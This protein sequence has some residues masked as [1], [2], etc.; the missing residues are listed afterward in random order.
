M[1]EL[2]NVSYRYPHSEIPVLEQVNLSLKPGT[3][4]VILGPT[5][6]G[7]TTL[8]LC[9]NGMIPQLLG[10]KLTGDLIIGGKDLRKYR[11]QTLARN[12]GLV[13]QDPETQ[14]FG[15]TVF[16]DTA[17]G[18]RNFLVPAAEIGPRV[19]DSLEK[20]RLKSLQNRNTAELSGGEKQRL[21]IAG[22]LALQPQVL[23]LD[24]PA[25]ELDPAGRAEIYQTVADL[26]RDHQVTILVAEHLAAEI[27]DK[28]DEVIVLH[29]G[30]VAW[31]GAPAELFRNI[32][33]LH[34]FGI[35]P[36]PVS[37][38]GWEFYQK[39]WLPYDQI[40]L[41]L[42]AAERM[43]RK[44]LTRYGQGC[45]CKSSQNRQDLTE[46]GTLAPVILQATDLTY[47]YSGQT[48]NGLHNINLQV[49]QGEFL[50]VV[51]PNGAGKTTLAKHFNGL[52]K[53]QSGEVLV[54]QM[55]TSF[56]QIA[57]LAQSVG[58]VFQNP[59]HQIFSVSVEKEL[60]YGLKNIGLPEAEINDRINQALHLV[61]LEDYRQVHPF[62]LGKGQRQLIALASVLVLQPKI[63]VIDEPTTGLDWIG[64]SKLMSL[65]KKLHEK[66][67]TIIMITHDMDLVAQYA[68]RVLVM[69]D[70]RILLD[71]NAKEVFSKSPVL[72]QAS[73]I[74]P[75]IVQLSERLQKI[76]LAEI[77]LDEREIIAAIIR[78]T[79]A[80][81]CLK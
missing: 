67:T 1:I 53:P 70:G 81:P 52:L 30:K 4:T 64:T 32:S 68:Q 24:E 74:P 9:L 59:D 50:A 20:V 33:L 16:E 37:L 19:V 11:V 60:A 38:V 55:N 18:L 45:F 21:A 51:G 15:I 6:A 43:I 2:Q 27:I 8:S 39:G 54:N 28:A 5:G 48:N 3:L 25:S 10:G 61:S 14:I 66:G 58:Y 26:C 76:G 31:Q 77:Y 75:Q 56:C 80:E 65:I 7:K 44:L 12:I 34:Q 23:V 47:E 79:E 13:L 41:D 78:E 40:P 36:L 46:T 49:R 29:Q 57:K 62:T 42:A 69:K 35:K 63:L 17:F 72:Q 73:I 22:I 71:G